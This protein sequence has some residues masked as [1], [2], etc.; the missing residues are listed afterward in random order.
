M[1]ELN[2]DKPRKLS[3]L[4]HNALDIVLLAQRRGR[5]DLTLAE[6][7]HALRAQAKPGALIEKSSLSRELTYLALD[8][9]L[10]RRSDKRRST[11]EVLP[12]GMAQHASPSSYAYYAPSARSIAEIPSGSTAPALTT[13]FY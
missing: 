6:I 7:L 9:F 11:W 8:G 2:T 1:S 4:A 10:L 3:H 12:A 5:L 13:D